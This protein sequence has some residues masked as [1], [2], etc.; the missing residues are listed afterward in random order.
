M[1]VIQFTRNGEFVAEHP[2]ASDAARIL[3][4]DKGGISKACW[5]KLKT[6]GGYKWRFAE[7][8]V[9]QAA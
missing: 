8:A 4:I 9:K 5:G 6:R 1:P 3:G 2:S 7:M